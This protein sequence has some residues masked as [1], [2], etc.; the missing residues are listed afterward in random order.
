[1][2]EIKNGGVP[3]NNFAAPEEQHREPQNDLFNLI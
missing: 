2:K 3:F 1:M